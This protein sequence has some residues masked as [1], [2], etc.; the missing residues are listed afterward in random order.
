MSENILFND[1]FPLSSG[2]NSDWVI[3]NAMGINPL[4]LTEWICKNLDLKPN[5]RVLDLGSGKA[6]SSIFLAKE[7]GVKVWSY[8]LWI[9]ATDNLQRIKEENLENMVFPIH[10]DARNL[11]FAEGFF[12]VII[13]IDS[14]IYY[15]TE[16]LYLNYLQKF[17][18]PEG[19][20]GIVVPGL[21]KEFVD[22][23]PDHLKDF[24]GQDCW[25]WHTIHWWRELWERTGLVD[26]QSS[27]I[28][29]DGCNLYVRWKEA[30]DKMGKNPWPKD[31]DILKKDAGEYVGFISLIAKRK[32]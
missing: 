3:N 27:E 26:I 5:M 17:I 7:F 13:S 9:N 24:W 22:G 30:Q 20:I 19:Q 1:K 2:Y 11:P 21:M 23:V 28:L 31:I 12:D 32:S 14:F 8:D 25:S 16:D 10:G 4:W 6:I 18:V 15:G 29:F